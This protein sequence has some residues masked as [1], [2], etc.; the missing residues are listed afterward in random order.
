[1]P[2]DA[3]IYGN[4]R[5]VEIPSMLD[6]QSKAMN[7]SSMAMQQARGAKQMEREDQ[8]AKMTAHLQKASIFGNALESIS[9]LPEQE[10]ALAYP[11]VRMELVS[12]GI[13]K[14]EDAPEQYD[15]QFYNPY[16]S[17]FQ[18]SKEGIEKRLKIAELAKTKA[19]I[20]K[21]NA[22]AGSKVLG[23]KNLTPGE[24]AADVAYAKDASDY[25]YQGGK[26]TIE[27]NMAQLR[28][29]VSTLESN[30]KLTGGITPR[31]PGLDSDMMQDTFNPKMAAVRDQI[32]GAVQGTLRAV[33]G[34][35][36]TEKEGAA[37]FNRAF[38]PRL[39]AEQNVKQATAV[40]RELEGM[41]RE[42]DAAMAHFMDNGTLKG[43]R[44]A[45]TMMAGAGSQQMQQQSGGGGFGM[46]SAAASE[47]PNFDSMSDEELKRYV[48]G[49]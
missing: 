9:G 15:P 20:G 32:R 8:E 7:L 26:S 47:R 30:P 38:N 39:S 40:I 46:K 3:S 21:L 27:K 25:Y 43:Y 44:P 13:I 48:G 11:K 36:F 2:I 10:K 19:E 22:E 41:A 37:I 29:A 24:K 42:K 34:A 6:S 23:L 17:R 4:L 12:S 49:K 1:M 18:Q 16:I 5:P 35:Q 45:R 14:P 31:V 28:D 33:L